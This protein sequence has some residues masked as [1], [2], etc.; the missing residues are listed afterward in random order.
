MSVTRPRTTIKRDYFIVD[1]DVPS[2]DERAFFIELR[3]EALHVRG[4]YTADVSHQRHSFYSR[5]GAKIDATY[6]IP[7]PVTDNVR[8]IHA[9]YD[10]DTLRFSFRR[11]DE[12]PARRLEIDLR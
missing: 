9:S 10:G 11:A 6:K 1:F 4:R 2:A 8:Y 7:V 3:G 12:Y 5:G